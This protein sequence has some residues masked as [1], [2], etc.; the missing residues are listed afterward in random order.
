M[1]WC[2]LFGFFCVAL[3]VSAQDDLG[4]EDLTLEE[5]LSVE[6]VTA[7]KTAQKSSEAPATIYVVSRE[8]IQSRGYRHLAELLEDIPE[9]EIQHKAAPEF[10]NWYT[11]RGISGNN[12]FVVLLNGFR[13]NSPTGSP[14]FIGENYPISN[15]LRVEVILGPAS[16]LYGADA[17]GGIVNIITQSGEEIDGIHA[18]A[19]VGNFGTVNGGAVLGGSYESIQWFFDGHFYESEEPDFPEEYPEDFAW[20]NQVY[21]QTGEVR[22][23]PFDPTI[24]D[25]GDPKPYGIPSE[26]FFIHTGLRSDNFEAAY[27]RLGQ[28][29]NASLATKP[30]YNLY[31]EEALYETV[32]ESISLKHT[33]NSDDGRLSLQTSLWR[34]TYEV[35]PNSRFINT[36]T[37]YES[38]WK[39][40]DGTTNKLEEQLNFTFNDNLNLVAGIS[41]ED[42]RALARSGDLPFR[43]DEDI[44]ADLQGQYY[45]GTNILDRDGND[46]TV[47]QSFFN[48]TYQNYGAFAQI[49]KRFQ[50]KAILTLGGRY[51]YN[52]RFGSTFNPRAGFVFL[53][54][55]KL[56]IKLLYGEGYLAPS[57]Y[58]AY[59]H[60]GAFIP[61]DENGDF[62][63]SQAQTVGLFG[64][65]WHLPN[66]DLK[67]EELQSSEISLSYS[68]TKNIILSFN[69]YQSTI[70]QL[71]VQGVFVGSHPELF[72]NGITFN[73]IEVGAAEI[74]V[75]TGSL[76]TEGGTL[77][78]NLLHGLK[79]WKLKTTA[80][81]SYS[82]GD[83]DGAQLPF[84][85]ENTLKLIFDL[86]NGPFHFYLGILNRS[87]SFH[88][89]QDENG[90]PFSNDSFTLVNA[91][92]MFSHDWKESR[93]A[94]FIK[95]RNLT[96]ERYYNVSRTSAEGFPAN[97]QDP[98]RYQAGIKVSF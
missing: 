47:P 64:P 55:D 40:G 31:I 75:N 77:A 67:P 93:I 72:P 11:L 60:F 30:E 26:A 80:A 90:V 44:P 52:T 23:S 9:I 28:N 76:D 14:H 12:K 91:Q 88:P 25:L 41:Y 38:G 18:L 82:D 4:F 48:L 62:A 83:I 3:M 7:S 22:V 65:F 87:K 13:V 36:F 42:V 66:P 92:A 51:D 33:Y 63:P 46:L 89:L 98:L 94:Y 16:A 68:F 8:Q 19:E 95:V 39:Y 86:E 15:A 27:A 71:V 69:A 5:L 53:P 85:A 29:H 61:V 97:P 56:K 24:I 2:F 70:D 43:F 74:P 81:Y 49:Q 34:G 10:S 84:S 20:Y 73:G 58:E 17:F 78:L 1:R 57:P 32:I 59:R 45:V 35:T 96:D 6:V 50:S 54:N 79:A 21:S 37:Q